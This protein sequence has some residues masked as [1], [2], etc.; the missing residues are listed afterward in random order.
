MTKSELIEVIAERTKITKG[1]AESVVNCIF[2]TM[3]T[4][5]EREEGIEI[6]GFGSF[7]IRHYKPYVGRNP[8]TNKPV[9]VSAK[10]LPF[11]KVGKDLK[12]L[13]NSRAHIPLPD[14]DDPDEHDDDDGQDEHDE[15]E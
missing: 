10:R 1:R 9:P 12:D 15:D 13:V 14:D 4:A 8:R 5:L 11:F 7:T 2:E 3:A 6:R